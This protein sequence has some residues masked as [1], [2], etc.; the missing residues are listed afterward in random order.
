M[1]ARVCVQ[2]CVYS[3]P[4]CVCPPVC[5][6]PGECA[7]MWVPVFLSWACMHVCPE[8]APVCVE[9]GQA[10]TVQLTSWTSFLRWHELQG[11][12]SSPT[13]LPGC[14]QTG[15]PGM[16]R[17]CSVGAR[18]AVRTVS[19]LS[20][21]RSGLTGTDSGSPQASGGRW[22]FGFPKTPWAREESPGS[23]RVLALH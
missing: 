1:H 13:V 6:H 2:T 23:S 22:G 21:T 9:S 11:A 19:R 8:C 20:P 15:D 5:V 17:G 18:S 10:S 4:V 14:T 7:C 3:G 12:S 16:L